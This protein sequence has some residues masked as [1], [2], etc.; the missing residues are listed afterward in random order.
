MQNQYTETI[1]IAVPAA[2]ATPEN[3]EKLRETESAVCL[4]FAVRSSQFAE[5]AVVDDEEED[6]EDEEDIWQGHRVQ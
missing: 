5:V 1:V 6:E 2:D 3:E 4:Q